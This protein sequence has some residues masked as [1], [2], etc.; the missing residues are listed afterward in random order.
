MVHFSQREQALFDLL[1]D[2]KSR[3][4]F[5]ACKI[6]SEGR[7]D[8]RRI[9]R[10]LI[11]RPAGFESL[12]SHLAH[13]KYI[14]WGAGSVCKK[15]VNIFAFFDADK[16]CIEIWDSNPEL[17]GG[18][19]CGIPIVAPKSVLND[20]DRQRLYLIGL[21]EKMRE[22][23]CTEIYF[24]LAGLGVPVDK[25][26]R[27]YWDVYNEWSYFDKDIVV[28][29]LGPDEV[30]V[31]GGSYDFY[32]SSAFVKACDSRGATVKR[33]YAF[34]PNAE[35][36][37]LCRKNAG[38]LGDKARVINAGLYSRDTNLYFEM[39]PSNKDCLMATDKVTDIKLPVI[40]LDNHV[41]A[42][43]KVTFIKYDVEGTELEAL[44]GASKIIRRDTPNLAICIYHKPL[45][46]IEIF[47]Y[48]YSL[49]PEYKFYIRI[50]GAGGGDIVLHAVKERSDEPLFKWHNPERFI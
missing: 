6:Y 30:F 36:G 9:F 41:D 46:Y 26:L 49:V 8:S 4:I 37:E 5:A 24:S 35:F 7:A 28:K 40:T 2:E 22:K 14:I 20:E 11:E 27:P 23:Q 10:D 18:E 48:I 34:E 32:T 42:D 50:Y 15:L 43:D 38:R 31:D 21:S 12:I 47:E 17:Q 44:K 3:Q 29:N 25:I 19:I 1:E 33:I 16:N 39:H 13:N 45:D